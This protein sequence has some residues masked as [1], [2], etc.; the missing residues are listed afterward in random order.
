[1]NTADIGEA[2]PEYPLGVAAL[3]RAARSFG[4]PTYSCA[5][6]SEAKVGDF[7]AGLEKMA[8]LMA[9]SAAGVAPVA[10]MGMLSRCSRQR[11]HTG[12]RCGS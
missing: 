8:G 2:G 5:L 12:P 9:C 3:A 10:N 4:L 6:H 1:M 7:Q 11:R